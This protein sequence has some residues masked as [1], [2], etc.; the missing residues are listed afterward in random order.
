M[1]LPKIRLYLRKSA[2]ILTAVFLSLLL[3][4]TTNSWA[5]SQ[6]MISGTVTDVKGIPLPFSNITEK[7]QVMVPLQ[8][9][10]GNT[11]F[12]LAQRRPWFFLI[13]GIKI[14]KPLP[15]GLPL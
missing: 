14:W 2:V 15:T 3:L 1:R 11:I 10:K 6:I 13:Q 8:M 9:L 12:E 4:F 5:Q 7:E